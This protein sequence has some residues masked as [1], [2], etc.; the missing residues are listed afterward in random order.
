MPPSI[1]LLLNRFGGMGLYV[2]SLFSQASCRCRDFCNKHPLKELD[3]RLNTS[4]FQLQV[5]SYHPLRKLVKLMGWVEGPFSTLRSSDL[6][7]LEASENARAQP[8]TYHLTP[9]T[10]LTSAFQSIQYKC[11]EQFLCM[12]EHTMHVNFVPSMGTYL[13]KSTSS[14]FFIHAKSQIAPNLL[15]TSHWNTWVCWKLLQN[16][17]SDSQQFGYWIPRWRIY[18]IVIKSSNAQLWLY[19]NYILWT[20]IEDE[21]KEPAKRKSAKV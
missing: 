19:R 14:G 16:Q 4:A 17:K 20:T 10:T 6:E 21:A 12:W 2:D 18:E 13:P 1:P 7:F 9:D 11:R 8:T 15:K 5:L 3:S